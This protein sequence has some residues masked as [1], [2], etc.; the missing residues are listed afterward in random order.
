VD[1]AREIARETIAK[2]V[3]EPLPAGAS[4]ALAAIVKEADARTEAKATARGR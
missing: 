4:E 1:T 2:H 3:P